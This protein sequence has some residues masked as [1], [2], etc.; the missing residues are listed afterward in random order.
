MKEGEYKEIEPDEQQIEQSIEEIILVIPVARKGSIHVVK[1][2]I[3]DGK[4]LKQDKEYVGLNKMYIDEWI[5][6]S[7]KDKI[8]DIIY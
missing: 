1:L 3:K 5:D 7:I 8:T 2:N 4:L 6:E